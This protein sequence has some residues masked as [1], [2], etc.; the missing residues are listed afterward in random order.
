MDEQQGEWRPDWPK[1]LW[2]LPLALAVASPVIARS[3]NGYVCDR[4]VSGFVWAV[5]T[6][7]AGLS[8]LLTYAFS[9]RRGR[10]RIGAAV[11]AGAV[12]F[13]VVLGVSAAFALAGST[14]D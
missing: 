12:T 4:H 9:R 7:T 2:L 5:V 1:S 6:A 11:V 14:C 8:A 3:T 13:G 10:E